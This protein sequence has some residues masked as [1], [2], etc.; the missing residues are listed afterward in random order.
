[1]RGCLPP[2]ILIIDD[3]EKNVKLTKTMLVHENYDLYECFS[4]QKALAFVHSINP[5]LILL[6]ILMPVV[7]GFEVCRQLKQDDRT[8][9]IPIIMVTAL[10]EKE[11]RKKA[12]ELGAD[13]FLNKPIDYMDLII[14]IKTNLRI[15]SYHDELTI[16]NSELAKKNEELNETLERM[17]ESEERFRIVVEESPFGISLIDQEGN[18]RYIDPKF[19]E[20]LGYNYHDIPNGNAWFEKA[21]PNAEYRKQVISTWI[22]DKKQSLI[23]ESRPRT[24]TVTCNNSE[25][26]EILFRPTTM[27]S[28]DQLV[29]YEDVT[30]KKRIEAQLQEAQKMEAIGTLAGGIAHDFNNI[31]FPLMGHAEMLKEDI[32]VDSP[33]QEN[34]DEI[35]HATLRAKDLVQQ[36]LTFSRQTEDEPKP[37]K[38]QHVVK[39]AIKLL[40]S[41]LPK[42]IDIQKY[43]DPNCGAVIAD[44]T[45]IHQ[46]VMNLSTNA[47]HAM[48]DTG[49]NLE[50]I[51]RQVQIEHTQSEGFEIEPGD[52][53]CLTVSDTGV[54]IE[55][56]ILDK[57]FDPF[58]TTKEMGKGT[59]LGLSVV[60]G[61]VKNYKG[62][63]RI[64]SEP[65]N[66]TKVQAYLPVLKQSVER[67]TPEVA[68][69]VQGGT[70]KILLVDDEEAI[71]KM[72]QQMLERMGY[73]VFTR[74]GSVDALE[75]F[76]ANPDQYDLIVSDMT[77]PNMT[78]IRLS[79][80]IKKIR[81]KTPVI[82]CTGFSDQIDEER[83]KALDIQGYIMKPI[84]KNE[85]TNAIR[86]VLDS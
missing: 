37:I 12:M 38:L 47:Y 16:S 60:H 76:K 40:Q 84:V 61:I 81:P 20:I 73:Q 67:K 58:Y 2:R 25:Q 31:L 27:V 48:E 46:I 34:V 13:D 50:I 80:E 33:L 64:D 30:E 42:T 32:S 35:M 6:D 22:N 77:M 69:Q 53:A 3:E 36:I 52:Y 65:G 74:T 28:G 86:E 83:C 55:K 78:G 26:K 62:D 56:Q 57:I 51:L 44:P 1:M 70:E 72:E 29:L 39:E 24:F 18:Y 7:D 85:F 41:T 5:D 71:I 11:N 59:G 14:R 23:G 63:V 19:T 82:I 21:F 9:A 66:G 45:R 15:K 17:K 75:A 68:E 4:G 79:Q 8:K 54:G 49:G 10:D 43:I